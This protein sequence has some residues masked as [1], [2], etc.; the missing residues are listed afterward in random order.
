MF[1]TALALLSA[2]SI[3]SS[4]GAQP[5]R[6]PLAPGV[7]PGSP[8]GP[9]T[10]FIPQPGPRFVP[11]R[12]VAPAIP[13]APYAPFS[14]LG[15]GFHGPLFGFGPFFNP[16]PDPPIVI[17]VEAPPALPP[18]PVEPGVVLANEFPA[19]LSVQFPAPARVWVNGTALAGGAKEVWALES[20]ALRVGT[21]HTF[22]FKARWE[23]NG[24]SYEATRSIG[25]RAGDRSRLQVVS[26][27]EVRQ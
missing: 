5:G 10:Q 22:E 17:V 21:P 20:G 16:Y 18:V 15:Y 2:V 25:V 1:R 27:T 13:G 11:P 4:V 9:G 12:P 19:T 24:K 23:L 7:H 26:G 6:L 14:P 8:I 3:A